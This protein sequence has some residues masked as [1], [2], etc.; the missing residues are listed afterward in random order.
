MGVAYSVGEMDHLYTFF[1]HWSLHMNTS[2]DWKRN[3]LLVEKETFLQIERDSHP[4][5][6]IVTVCKPK[7]SP[8]VCSSPSVSVSEDEEGEGEDSPP[9]LKHTSHILREQHTQNLVRN[10]PARLQ[11]SAWHL[12]Y[13]T[14]VHGTSLRTLYRNTGDI[15]Q[16][17]L[18]LI[19]DTHN[20]VFGAFSS[21]PFR[22]SN[23]C[24]GTGETFLFSFS[25]DFKMFG[26]SGENSYFV[27]GF[28]DSL[29]LGGGGGPFG[30]WLDAD[31]LRGSTFSCDTFCNP[32][33]SP[34]H[35]FTVQT[36]EVWSFC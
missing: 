26:W 7:R 15:D 24:Y 17:V 12:I 13:S 18:L 21:D 28:L 10:I 9:V 31:L 4:E 6:M 14:E 30:L 11:C 5:P 34:H 16:P 29:Q 32:P 27:R 35:D 36:L 25:P 3:F 2:P 22:V 19:K 8:S 1:N 20:Q 33:L 23:C